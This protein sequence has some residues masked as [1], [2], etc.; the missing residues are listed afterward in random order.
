MSDAP[1]SW[2][3]D[4]HQRAERLASALAA[5]RLA[6]LR[7]VAAEAASLGSP[8]YV[9][10]GFVRDLLLGRPTTDLD[11]VIEGDAVALAR[12]LAA[13]YG[14]K[15]TVHDRFRTAQWSLP[16]S[17][18]AAQEAE[19]LSAAH[20]RPRPARSATL[21]LITARS[22]S[23]ARPGALP[24]VSPGSLS[25]D[26]R[27]R[28]F[29]VN[30]LALRLD[31]E[32]FG[33]L[34][35]EL[36]GLADLAAGRIRALHPASYRDDPTRILRA[37]RYEQRCSFRIDPPDLERMAESGRLLERLSGERLRHE[38]DLILEEPQAA[39]M[40]ARLA[41]LEALSRIHRSLTWDEET[42]RLL[43]TL[44]TPEP[45]AWRG[46]P[47]LPR[48]SRRTALGYLLWLGPL[49]AGEI[50]AL[51]VR[52]SLTAGLRAALLSLSRLLPD[53]ASLA[54]AKPSAV[55]ARL[56][57]LPLLAVCAAERLA[58]GSSRLAVESYLA[59]W[60]H[61]RAGTTGTG[62]KRR[63]LAPG[64]VYE[65]ILRRLREAR[66]DGEVQTDQ[67]ERALLDR[68]IRDL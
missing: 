17:L 11:L 59:R 53:L 1:V 54:D 61:V 12:A 67:E 3:E 40:L 60:R 21:D 45:E 47:D 62:L 7:D 24:S 52:L 27:R 28:D 32:H 55:T 4:P 46:V 48:V 29:T 51:T 9:V 68:L 25:D 10:G 49:A 65:R 18:A 58:R 6:L 31:G 26:M 56:Q 63:G 42:G 2:P 30:T 33:E 50:Q 23:Y 38:L 41:A 8:L 39:A 20:E 15:V 57:D 19:P 14:G 44:N 36:G 5:A 13:K 34:R 66:L 35:D 37:V 43:E 64:P 22:E 16:D